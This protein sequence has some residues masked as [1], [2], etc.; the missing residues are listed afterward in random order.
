MN[1]KSFSSLMLALTAL[2]G[3]AIA[4]MA[5]LGADGIGSVAGIGGVILGAMWALYAVLGGG[6]Q[7]T[8]G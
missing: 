4:I 6:R 7:N 5:I 3:V 2:F 8:G 1:R